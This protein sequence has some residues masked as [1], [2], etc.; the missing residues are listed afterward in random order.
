M[1][2]L[3]TKSF[4]IEKCEVG[5]KSP[6]FIIAEV[7]QAHDGSLGLAHSFIE[8]AAKTKVNA[9]KFQ[10]HIAAAES[11]L[12]EPWR[13]KFSRQDESR[14]AY[15]KRMEFTEP[16]WKELKEHANSLGLIFLSSPFSVEAVELLDRIG[17]PAW[18]IGSGEVT[19]KPLFAAIA[20]TKKPILLSTGMSSWKEISD[21]VNAI[22]SYNIPFALF[23]CTSIYPTPPEKIGLNIISE[24]KE[25]FSVPVGL[26]DHSAKFY[27]GLA[28][29]QAGADLIEVHLTLSKNMFGPDVTSSL[30]PEELTLLTEGI[31]HI[32]KLRAHPVNKDLMAEELCAMKAVFQKSIVAKKD[33][34]AGTR[35]TADH[36]ALKKPGTGLSPDKLENIIGKILNQSLKVD[37]QILESHLEA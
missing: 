8:T 9:I 14:Y 33:L 12:Q 37:D 27:T 32:E 21:A 26:S 5:D 10:T 31:R 1:S 22:E 7:A 24:L 2:D 35:I 34:A 25:K 19:N 23:Q 20:K 30:T 13:V 36:L 4:K 3:K 16:Q 6:C 15:W 18:K 17:M 11:T 28:A 29:A